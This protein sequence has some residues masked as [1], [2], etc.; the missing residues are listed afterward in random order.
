MPPPPLKGCTHSTG[1]RNPA[2]GVRDVRD[3]VA[4]AQ[5]LGMELVADVPAPSNNTVLVLQ[6]IAGGPMTVKSN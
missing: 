6:R 4:V 3:V 5:S 1:R 2:W